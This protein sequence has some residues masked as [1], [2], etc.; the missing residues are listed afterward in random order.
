MLKNNRKAY[1]LLELSIV[2]VIISILISGAMTVSVGNISNAKVK[3]TKD[4]MKLI[5]NALGNYVA[6]NRKLPCP[7]SITDSKTASA[8]YG[9][10]LSS[11][12]GMSLSSGGV[13]VSTNLLYGMV[14]VATLGLAKE[15]GED[16]FED[17]IAYVVDKNFTDAAN[18]S[19]FPNFAVP[20]FSTSTTT[21]TSN[22]ITVFEKSGSATI[23]TISNAVFV[24]IS[25]GPNKKG[26]FGVNSSTQNTASTDADEISNY[27]DSGSPSFDNSFT[28]V[29]ENSDLFDDILEYSNPR[30]LVAAFN[31]YHLLPCLNSVDTDPTNYL[32]Y[33][34][35][36]VANSKNAWFGQIIIGNNCGSVSASD[37]DKNY[38]KKCGALGQWI[39]ISGCNLP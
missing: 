21:N 14:P 15:I 32:N 17:K 33:P 8:S 24:L 19:A 16:G 6:I 20:T 10:A 39:L 31:L 38:S 37:S 11:C 25:A 34:D 27:L 2:I 5:Y 9:Q 29:S 35:G 36:G 26:A 18:L 12:S 23:T 22:N 13:Y 1:S 7:A 3:T 4:R 30:Q 28:R